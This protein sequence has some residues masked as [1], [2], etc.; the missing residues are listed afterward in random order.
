[1]GGKREGVR[2]L[3]KSH[4]ASTKKGFFKKRGAGGEEKRTRLR[5][6]PSSWP[7]CLLPDAQS[8]RDPLC[9]VASGTSN[10]RK[11]QSK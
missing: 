7:R 3:P 10:H 5:E 11:R 8:G 1:M 2:D 6:E 4:F 9:P